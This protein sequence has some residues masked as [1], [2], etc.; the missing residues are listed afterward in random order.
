M[1]PMRP[2][3]APPVQELLQRGRSFANQ[4]R[5]GE[6]AALFDQAVTLAPDCSDAHYEL[7][8]ACHRLGHLA[9]AEQVFRTLLGLEPNH[10]PTR[11][12][13]SAVLI[14]A[15]RPMEAEALL[16]AC[17][18][19]PAPP[20]F[21]AA[22]QTNLGLAQ[23]RQRKDEDALRSYDR[24]RAL[25]AA[26]HEIALHRAEALQNL[27]RHDEA[28]AEYRDA[29]TRFPQSPALHRHY[30][31][32]L[33]RLGQPEDY[34]KSYDRASPTRDLRLGKAGLLL[35]EGRAEDALRIC[36]TLLRDDPQD[37]SAILG[38]ANA[39]ITLERLAE[40]AVLLGPALRHPPQDAS[41]L[42]LAAVV[43]LLG[44]DPVQALGVCE[45]AL[46]LWPGD[47]AL[48]ATASIGARM[49]D[50][51]QDEFLNGYDRFIGTFDL[52]A[53]PGY[54]SMNAFNE[55]LAHCLKNM[56]PDT[57]GFLDQS[58]RGGT[59]TPDHLFGAGHPLVEQLRLQIDEAVRAYVVDLEQDPVH[60]FLS[61]RAGGFAYA[62][63]WSS[64]LRDGG[65]HRNH[66][67]QSGW[68][69]S[70]YY[71]D[72]PPAV[73]DENAKPGWIKF[74][75]PSFAAPLKNPIRRA[76]KPVPGRLLLFPSYTWHGTIPFQ[77]PSR[78][79]VAFDVIPAKT[80]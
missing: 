24:A 3:L 62:G 33:Y 21:Q 76:I 45:Q 56:H 12:G 25:G 78:L 18:A 75:E 53:P 52:A 28:L 70:C 77:G 71:V 26:P 74:G 41:L 61:R 79:T 51:R 35:Q 34:L 57:A 7:A 44:N 29:L 63:S 2:N 1:T 14:D 15:G 37:H 54:S 31:H 13:L 30:N 27:G 73:D 55:E 17:L 39:L 11:L 22:V 9:R 69:S 32:L 64:L 6:A 5:D 46:A 60:P 48:I 20:A 49:T 38:A 10:A 36:R 43:C 8:S 4:N 16:H 80:G 23:R 65:F 67:H 47:Q 40:V 50:P 66:I 42:N 19:A 58:L 59:Q 72:V 68:I